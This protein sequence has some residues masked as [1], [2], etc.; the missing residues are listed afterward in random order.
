M[1]IGRPCRTSGWLAQVY[2]TCGWRQ[3]SQVGAMA[4][5]SKLPL[6]VSA[7]ESEMNQVSLGESWPTTRALAHIDETHTRILQW[8]VFCA[9]WR[10]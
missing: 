8:N 1:I 7:S 4:A 6:C 9:P 3:H 10:T 2:A 5:L